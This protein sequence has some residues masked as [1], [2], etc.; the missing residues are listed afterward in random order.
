M[1][2]ILLYLY[3]I[4]VLLSNIMIVDMYLVMNGI[5]MILC[6]ISVMRKLC[7]TGFFKSL[8]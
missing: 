4:L 5:P 7:L 1:L 3:F 6:F 8:F 2:C